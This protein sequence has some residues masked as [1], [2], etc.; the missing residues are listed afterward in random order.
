MAKAIESHGLGFEE[1]LRKIFNAPPPHPP[2]P[3]KKAAKKPRKKSS[4]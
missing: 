4:K 2:K 1:G 3:A